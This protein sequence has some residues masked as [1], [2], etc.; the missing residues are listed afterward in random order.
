MWKEGLWQIFWRLRTRNPT[1]WHHAQSFQC[2]PFD[3]HFAWCLSISCI[4]LPFY[5]PNHVWLSTRYRIHTLLANSS[6]LVSCSR[7]LSILR[8]CVSVNRFLAKRLSMHVECISR[9][10]N[11]HK[12]YET[13]NTSLYYWKFVPFLRVLDD[14]ILKATVCEIRKNCWILQN[15]NIELII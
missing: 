2:F 8:S 15:K 13:I 11:F 7:L 9:S 12:N 6:H 3:R 5:A 14:M 10:C 4:A 1:A